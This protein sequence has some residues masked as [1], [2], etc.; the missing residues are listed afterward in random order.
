MLEQRVHPTNHTAVR[1]MPG[2]TH[3]YTY[4]D[5]SKTVIHRADSSSRLLTV[6]F[7]RPVAVSARYTKWTTATGVP[8][9]HHQPPLAATP[10]TATRALIGHS[11]T[12]TSD[13]MARS[14]PATHNGPRN[15]V[16]PPL[17]CVAACSHCGFDQCYTCILYFVLRRARSCRSKH[18]IVILLVDYAACT[19]DGICRT[20]RF[21][22]RHRHLI[23]KSKNKKGFRR[24]EL[25]TA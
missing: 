8:R 10:T 17:R 18:G 15:P 5:L 6:L 3:L 24:N 4:S 22:S 23:S 13:H 7:D 11:H 12:L 19:D 9:R 14:S 2:T 25:E 16:P 20:H 21:A 1:T